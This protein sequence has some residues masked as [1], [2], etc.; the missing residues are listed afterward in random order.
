MRLFGT[1]PSRRCHLELNGYLKPALYR[2]CR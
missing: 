1:P 2:I